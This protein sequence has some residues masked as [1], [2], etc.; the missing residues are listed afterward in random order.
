MVIGGTTALLETDN[1][2]KSN[3]DYSSKNYQWTAARG[4]GGRLDIIDYICPKCHKNIYYQLHSMNRCIHCGTPLFSAP[5]RKLN[6]E[7]FRNMQGSYLE[8]LRYV[9]PKRRVSENLGNPDHKHRPCKAAKSH[10]HV[11]HS[12]P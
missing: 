6:G 2:G 1:P 8:E 4:E 3:Q 7:Q 9:G 10:R 11:R 5:R 12:S